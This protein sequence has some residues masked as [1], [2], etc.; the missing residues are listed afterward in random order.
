MAH[1]Q[2][3]T[4]R[5]FAHADPTI[6]DILDDPKLRVILEKEGID[7]AHLSELLSALRTRLLAQRWR[8]AA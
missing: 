2:L 5:R 3:D 8:A 6:E 4:C 7:A 1:D